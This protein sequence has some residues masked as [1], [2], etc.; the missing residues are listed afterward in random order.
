MKK[1][2]IIGSLEKRMGDVGC[3][4]WDGYRV[5]AWKE[6]KKNRWKVIKSGSHF[7]I[8]DDNQQ[9]FEKTSDVVCGVCGMVIEWTGGDM[10]GN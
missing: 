10:E 2:I 9:N 1:Q 3:V 5:E 8:R 7:T 6:I 4:V